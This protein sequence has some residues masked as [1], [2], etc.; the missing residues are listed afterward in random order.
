[1]NYSIYQLNLYECK[2][3]CAKLDQDEECSLHACA[4]RYSIHG[5]G[6]DPIQT[7]KLKISL[8]RFSDL[9]KSQKKLGFI[10]EDE[11]RQTRSSQLAHQI[12]P[13]FRSLA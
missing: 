12:N 3:Q 6:M 13:E 4:L 9:R 1:M 7:F 11:K 10:E 2:D 8:P 5:D